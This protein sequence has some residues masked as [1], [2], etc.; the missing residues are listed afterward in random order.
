MLAQAGGHDKRLQT[1]LALERPFTRVHALVLVEAGALCER[2]V[3]LGAR[4]GPQ[5]CVDQ[6]VAPK[7]PGCYEGLVA[8]L[9]F[10]RPLT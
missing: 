5:T 9:A 2:L 7:V 8:A 10:V 6:H 4:E 3:A 1:F